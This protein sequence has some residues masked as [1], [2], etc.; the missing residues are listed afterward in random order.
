MKTALVHPY[1]HHAYHS[2]IGMQKYSADAIGFF[3]FYKKDDLIDKLLK[4]TSLNS[5]L[6]GY[7]NEILDGNKR[8]IKVKYSSKVEY[9]YA[10]SNPNYIDKYINNF[11]DWVISD[12]ENIE[13]IHVLQDYCN[14]VIRNAY[15]SG[16]KIIY[17]QI[18]PFDY[19]QKK[20]LIEEVAEAKFSNSYVDLRFPEWKIE[21][22][23][24]NLEM[25]SLVITASDISE[26]SIK[27]LTDKKIVTFPYG[28]SSNI[29]SD[30]IFEM[31]S[32]RRKKNKKINFLYVGAINLIKGVRYIIEAAKVLKNK[33]IHFTFL[34]RPS[35]EE[36]NKLIDQIKLLSNCTYIESVPHIEI[37]KLYQSN[38]VFIFQGLCE[39]FGM[40][41]LEAMSNG[42][43]CIVSE[44]GKGVIKD[45][46]SGF[47]NS[48]MDVNAIVEAILIFVNNPDL[49]TTMGDYA[50]NDVLNYTWDNFSNN[51]EKIYK[52]L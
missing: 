41:T 17:E 21:K 6:S 13:T 29:I 18:Q 14:K 25:A 39:G 28:A 10:K 15:D 4:H 32:I 50:K 48:D 35:F 3:G 37:N 38:D 12:T 34:G 51:I 19:T 47:I 22:Q 44:G 36:D 52:D 5:K 40:V 1:K 16:K 42:M 24:E 45:K 27:K 43:P 7:S 49:I 20:I 23:I 2:L 30:D 33:D 26:I 8:N 46:K 11:Q 31:M 9:L